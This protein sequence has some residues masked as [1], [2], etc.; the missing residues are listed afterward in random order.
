LFTNIAAKNCVWGGGVF[1]IQKNEMRFYWSFFNFFQS[2][3]EIVKIVYPR[4]EA[5]LGLMH[6]YKRDPI[7]YV[8]NIQR[9]TPK[10]KWY[11]QFC[12]YILK[13]TDTYAT[14]IAI[15]LQGI[16]DQIFIL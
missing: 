12:I 11:A 3:P 5:S 1:D 6:V 7:K 4:V 13:H 8:N 15:N 2:L 9:V 14:V 16:C 10:E